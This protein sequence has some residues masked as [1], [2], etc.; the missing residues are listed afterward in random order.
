MDAAA[1]CNDLASLAKFLD[2]APQHLYS[3]LK[4]PRHYYYRFEIPKRDGS[5]RQIFCPKA[6]LR[7]VQRAILDKLLTRYEVHTAAHAYVKG[8]SA[9]TCA[10]EIAGS[11]YMLRLDIKNFF[12]SISDRRVY[13]LFRSL[14]FRKKAAFILT[15]L[16]TFR[17]HAVQGAPTS[18]YISNL[19][20]HRLDEQLTQACADWGIRYIR[21]SDD[22]FFVS[23]SSV[24][25]NRF[26]TMVARIVADHGFKLNTSKSKAFRSGGQKFALGFRLDTP[27]PT[28]TRRTR[29]KYRALFHKAAMNP[30]WG[31]S[32]IATLEGVA[33]WY[34][35]VAGVD[36][37][38]RDY[39][40]VLG[41]LQKIKAH[42]PF[43]I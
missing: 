23:N 31:K 18:P 11:E 21:Y 32:K 20:F 33:A 7:G 25:W 24:G 12:P 40:S 14:G 26:K 8:R 6:A 41:S 17:K 13:G 35:S 3:L 37:T 15:R 19:I 28:L 38:Y 2:F 27:I 5:S 16:T 29:H 42:E 36:E 1:E 9:L 30:V 34:R 39:Q 10:R 4:D 43:S 22:L